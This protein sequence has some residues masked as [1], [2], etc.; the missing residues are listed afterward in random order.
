MINF[1]LKMYI[2]MQKTKYDFEFNIHEEKKRKLEHLSILQSSSH[3]IIMLLLM[4][5]CYSI[6]LLFLYFF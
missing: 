3:Y 2:N 1:T 5:F 4:L 6:G